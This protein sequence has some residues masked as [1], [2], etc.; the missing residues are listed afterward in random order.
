MIGAISQSR[1]EL[2]LEYERRHGSWIL[3]NNNTSMSW[4]L[5]KTTT[6]PCVHIATPD[7]YVDIAQQQQHFHVLVIATP[8]L[9]LYI[10]HNNNNN[11]A[12]SSYF[13]LL[14]IAISYSWIN[15]MYNLRLTSIS[16]ILQQKGLFGTI[17]KTSHCPHSLLYIAIPDI[18]DTPIF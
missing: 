7:L 5:H 12:P 11:N 4:I 6:L 15:I 17:S 13:H 18:Q 10:A 9:Y 2:T 8:D 3:H 1:V 16:W 14:D